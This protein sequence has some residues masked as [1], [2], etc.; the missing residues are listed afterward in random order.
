[1]D[2]IVVRAIRRF[3]ERR[4]SASNPTAPSTERA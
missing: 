2:Q 1:V 3:C 4:A